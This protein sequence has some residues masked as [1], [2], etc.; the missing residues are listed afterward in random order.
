[1]PRIIQQG[2]PEPEE[3]QKPTALG[4]IGNKITIN[5]RSRW[6]GNTG[7]RVISS[8]ILRAIQTS[9]GFYKTEIFCR[10][11][12]LTKLPFGSYIK[13]LICGFLRAQPANKWL[14]ASPALFYEIRTSLVIS[15]ST[16]LSDRA[17]LVALLMKNISVDV[18]VLLCVSYTYRP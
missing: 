16:L 14:P 6:M 2:T 4:R 11:R 3:V 13:V 17:N 10:V 9:Y 1:V 8:I 12:H 5:G 18:T 7:V 15:S